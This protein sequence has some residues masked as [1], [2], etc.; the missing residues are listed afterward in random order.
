MSPRSGKRFRTSAPA[1]DL[2]V[3]HRHA[4]GVDIHAAEHFVSVPAEEVPVGFV[5]PD[6][7]LPLGV[8]KFG[9]TTGELEALAAWLPPL[10]GYTAESICRWGETARARRT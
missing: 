4:A 3:T 1:E 5:N 2:R 9:T 7:K 10:S 6:A 8:R